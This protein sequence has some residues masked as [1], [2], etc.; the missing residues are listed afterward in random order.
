MVVADF[1]R[2]EPLREAILRIAVSYLDAKSIFP[3]PY[4][5]VPDNAFDWLD[6]LF[7]GIESAYQHDIPAM[8]P[9]REYF[10]TFVWGARCELMECQDFLDRLAGSPEFHLSFSKAL[11][12]RENW[13]K[14]RFSPYEIRGLRYGSKY[15]RTPLKMPGFEKTPIKCGRCKSVV[16]HWDVA[17]Y[18]TRPVTG[19]LGPQ[20]ATAWRARYS[21]AS[22]AWCKGCKTKMVKDMVFP[23]RTGTK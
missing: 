3:L 21:V 16:V 2:L 12:E 5:A 13:P 6:E 8:E 22:R 14:T 15:K 23:W 18:N 1:F 17:Y 4:S 19:K 7:A 20:S 9:L 11:L 10:V